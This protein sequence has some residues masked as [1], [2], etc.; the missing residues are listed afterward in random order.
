MSGPFGPRG[1]DDRDDLD[2]FLA[3]DDEVFETQ[4]ERARR[5]RE[6]AKQSRLA[7]VS[8]TTW[9]VGVAALLAILY[10]TVNS[11][12]TKSPGSRGVQDGQ[13]MPPFTAPLALADLKCKTED[14]DTKDCD[15]SVALAERKG[16]PKACD[17]Q[18]PNTLNSC[19][20]V[21][22]GPLALAFMVAPSQE[23]IDQV[24]QL[25]KVAPRV[26]GVQI[27]A[28]AIR[29]N[30]ADINAII[31]K[32]RW[33]FPVAY[34]HDGAVA[35][36]YAVAVCPTITFAYKGGI[37]EHTSFGAQTDAQILEHLRAITKPRPAST[38]TP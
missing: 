28:V 19:N 9:L 24:D 4:K 2:E 22:T 20:T 31:R 25:S 27:A 5:E 21:N 18:L 30:H 1:E 11:I 16:H 34:D 35:N 29:G 17:I 32:H 15:A 13:Q 6:N 23:C 14:G 33:T 12:T 37:V 7:S 3:K 38:V 8:S 26:A 36:A 10:I